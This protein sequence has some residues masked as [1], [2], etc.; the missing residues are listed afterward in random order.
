MFA[1]CEVLIIA[2][3]YNKYFSIDDFST[4]LKIIMPNSKHICLKDYW[5]I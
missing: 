5:M 2:I 1:T 4:L 3:K